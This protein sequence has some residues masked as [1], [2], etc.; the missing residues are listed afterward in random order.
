MT[1]ILIVDDEESVRNLLE[2][3][4]LRVGYECILA[5]NAAEAREFI[6]KRNFELILCDVTM[7]GE[8]G[9]NFIRY[10]AAEYPRIATIMVTAADD[11]EI[12]ETAMEAGICGY[13]IKPFNANELI[14]NV[15]NTLRRRELE[16]ADQTYRE[17]LERKVEE[18]T[19]EL[20]ETLEG[21]IYALTTT[22][23][24]RDPYTAGHQQR[25]SDLASAIAK[26]MGF[27]KDKI[28]GIRMAGMLHDIGKIAIPIAILTKPGKLSKT[29]FERIK[30]HSQVGYDILKKI[31]FPWPLAQSVLQHHERIDGS[32]YPD[33][34][35]GK[36]ILTE[37]KIL[38]VADVVEAIAFHR[39]Y[40]Q[41]LGIDKALEEILINKGKLYDVEAANVCLKI[42]KDK[43]FEFKQDS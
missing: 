16:I 36:Q 18:R 28:M 3:V 25:V 30:K 40:R 7:P 9:I 24:Y 10:V 39:P 13:M 2:Q 8:S 29:K 23:E 31:K 4:L 17:N 34:L 19:A 27:S 35:S 41:A 6:K 43:E 37:A 33:G 21:T 11:P 22:V 32:G 42:F 5:A 20:Q 38:G 14:I 12:A 15:R 1:N 26:K